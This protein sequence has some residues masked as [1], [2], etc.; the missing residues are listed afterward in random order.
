MKT[1]VITGATSGIGYAVAKALCAQ[2]KRVIGIGRIKEN[3]DIARNDILTAFAQADITYFYGDLSQQSEVN[4][5]AN[6]IA[7]CLD[8]R[9]NGKLDVL[10]NNA[11][12]VRNGYTT[13]AEGYELQFA[14]NHLSGFLLTYRLLPY[15]EKNTGR[16]ILTGS[17]SHKHTRIN[18]NDIMYQKRYSC[19]MAYKQSKLCNLMFAGEFNRRFESK[20]VRAF[21]VDPGL[22]NTNIGNKQTTGIVNR[23]WSLRKKYGV[24]PDIAAQSYVFLCNQMPM[25]QGLYY[26]RCALRRYSKRV[27]N[28]RDAQRLFELSEQLCGVAFN[29]ENV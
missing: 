2:G 29:K 17:N 13:T 7:V 26:Y 4:R 3:C 21:V 5:I 8:A 27:D 16:I 28:L 6:Q 15:L 10:I 25:P 18:W 23:F 9:A 24:S 12:G 20:D 22:V 14:L 11:G 1:V 19:L